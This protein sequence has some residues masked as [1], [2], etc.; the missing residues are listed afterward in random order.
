[1]KYGKDTTDGTVVVVF[2]VGGVGP[3]IEGGTDVVVAAGSSSFDALAT[4]PDTTPSPT[5]PEMSPM[6]TAAPIPFM[7]LVVPSHHVQ[8]GSRR[9][10]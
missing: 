5:T 4:S 8:P 1:M 9:G 10:R 6:A 3:S 2:V 7:P